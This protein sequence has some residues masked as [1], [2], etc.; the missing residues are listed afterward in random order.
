MTDF[1][2]YLC[3]EGYDLLTSWDGLPPDGSGV[4]TSGPH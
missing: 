3:G 4:Y 2:E 1:Q